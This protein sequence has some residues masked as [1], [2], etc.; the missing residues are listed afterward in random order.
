MTRTTQT[1][2]GRRARRDDRS[3]AAQRAVLERRLQWAT[4]IGVGLVAA[5]GLV[6]VVALVVDRGDAAS[7]ATTTD[8][9]LPNPMGGPVRAAP[10]A[11]GD[12]VAFGGLQV[13]SPATEMGDV[14]LGVTLVPQWIVSNPGDAAAT[15]TVGQPRVLEGCCPGPVYVDEQEAVPGTTLDVPAGEQVLV[16]FPLQ[17]HPGMDGPHHL[18]VPVSSEGEAADLHVTGNFTAGA[19]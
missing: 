17:M 8:V 12:P 16:Q 6:L 5:L 3:R 2:A 11:T 13:Q 15:L 19:A 18:T 4:R 9:A 10:V 1:P 14:P 7:T